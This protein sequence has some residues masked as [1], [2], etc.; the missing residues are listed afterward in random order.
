DGKINCERAEY[1][2]KSENET[3][4]S[5]ISLMKKFVECLV[6]I[7]ASLNVDSS[8]ACIFVY[9]EKEKI[10]IQDSLLKLITL[11]PDKISKKV[12][13]KAI[14][15]FFNIFEDCSLLLA[16]GNDYNR[17][18]LLDDELREFPRLI[19]LEQS[20]KENIAIKVPGF[21]RITDVWEQMVKPNL[22]YDQVQYDLNDLETY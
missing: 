13:H 9:S 5:F 21:Y 22:K 12:Q 7:F 6:N 2:S 3:L 17:S 8:R 18:G 4:L 10:A 1:N 20:L 14:R 19:V 15:C 11:N 16:A